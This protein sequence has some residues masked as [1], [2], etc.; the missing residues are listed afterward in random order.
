VKKGKKLDKGSQNTDV[1][2]VVGS[3]NDMFMNLQKRKEAGEKISE[4]DVRSIVL[5]VGSQIYD[6]GLEAGSASTTKA[7]REYREIFSKVEGQRFPLSSMSSST[8]DVKVNAIQLAAIKSGTDPRDTG[9]LIAEVIRDPSFNPSRGHSSSGES[10]KSGDS[11]TGP[12]APNLEEEK[13]DI[14]QESARASKN[15][16]SKLAPPK[17]ISLQPQPI[18]AGLETPESFNRENFIDRSTDKKSKGR[19][20]S[21]MAASGDG[22]S[23]AALPAQI[24]QMPTQVIQPLDSPNQLPKDTLGRTNR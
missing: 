6:K 24:I 2:S 18:I 19:K 22:S 20:D 9:E 8:N 10:S 13:L 16:L 14:E 12:V 23:D 21:F 3:W 5:E 11:I 17:D 4:S 7:D 1:G 15:L